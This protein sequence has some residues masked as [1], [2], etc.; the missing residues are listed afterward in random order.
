MIL[1]R[2]RRRYA[3]CEALKMVP[4]TLSVVFRTVW[5]F[6]LV[7]M[8]VG[9]VEKC[10]FDPDSVKLFK[11]KTVNELSGLGCRLLEAG[12]DREE[13]LSGLLFATKR[14]HNIP[15]FLF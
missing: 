12:T 1:R 2:L 4:G 15:F 8:A 9:R 3:S 6:A 5:H 7:K 11:L 13:V 10:P 14:S